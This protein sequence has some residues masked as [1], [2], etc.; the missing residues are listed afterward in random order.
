MTDQR[1][2]MWRIHEHQWINPA[3]I[4]T[5]HDLPEEGYVNVYTVKDHYRFYGMRRHRILDWLG[6][7]SMDVRDGN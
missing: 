6:E 1:A 4:H 7:Q 3:L 5:I 2:S